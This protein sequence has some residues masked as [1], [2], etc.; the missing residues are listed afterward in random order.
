MSITLTRARRLTKKIIKIEAGKKKFQHYV[1]RCDEW[2]KSD[3][4]LLN[5]TLKKLTNEE[6]IQ[7][8]Y[9]NGLIDHADYILM[10]HELKQTKVKN[11]GK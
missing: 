10:K 5:I 8:G 4:K 6:N 9:E 1:K 7:Y 3:K 11:N 2:I